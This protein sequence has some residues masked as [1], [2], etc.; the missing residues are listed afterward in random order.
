MLPHPKAE[1]QWFMTC[2]YFSHIFVRKKIVCIYAILVRSIL[3]IYARM[4]YNYTFCLLVSTFSPV[5]VHTL[6]WPCVH[7]ITLCLKKL[8]RPCAYGRRYLCTCTSRFQSSAF[9]VLYIYTKNCLLRSITFWWNRNEIG[10]R[11]LL[12][13]GVRKGEK[14]SPLQ[15]PQKGRE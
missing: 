1:H 2:L 12:L 3:Y 15:L 6:Y 14:D 10:V 7:S 4:M 11:N 5:R 8:R 13:D 9:Y